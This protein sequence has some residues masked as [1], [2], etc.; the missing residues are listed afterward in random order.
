M[1]LPNMI[2]PRY[3]IKID[4]FP[5]VPLLLH[6]LWGGMTRLKPATQSCWQPRGF[7]TGIAA[8]SWPDLPPKPFGQPMVCSVTLFLHYVE[9]REHADVK[10]R[11]R[12]PASPGPHYR[13]AD[14][15][16]PLRLSRCWYRKIPLGPPTYL[17][18]II[19]VMSPP[20]CFRK[21]L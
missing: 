9:T 17:Y 13:A 21:Y 14:G 8:K 6:E 16:H 11:S 20:L 3:I 1:I 15:R 18:S 7:T 4:K 12:F 19:H 10:L 5:C 2:Y